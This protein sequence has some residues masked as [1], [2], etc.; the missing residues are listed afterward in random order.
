MQ[1][2]YLSFFMTVI[3]LLSML[4]MYIVASS[5]IFTGYSALLE[6]LSL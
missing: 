2:H 5:Q 4:I 3:I 6:L 1:L